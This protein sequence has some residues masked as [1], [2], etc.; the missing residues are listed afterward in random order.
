M[1]LRATETDAR[2]HIGLLSTIM[3]LVDVHF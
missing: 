2:D 3:A 1:I